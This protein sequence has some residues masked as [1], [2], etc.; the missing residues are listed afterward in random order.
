ME[1]H[2]EAVQV[3]EKAE[4]V[5]ERSQISSCIWFSYRRRRYL[6]VLFLLFC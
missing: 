4:H 2:I 3:R 5:S 1:F 6:S